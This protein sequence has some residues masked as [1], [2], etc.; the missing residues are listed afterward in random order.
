[1]ITSVET[2]MGKDRGGGGKLGE[3]VGMV[4]EGVREED[5]REG[6]EREREREKG[7]SRR[8]SSLDYTRDQASLGT[9]ERLEEDHSNDASNQFRLTAYP[10]MNQ[11]VKN[12]P[13]P[14][15]ISIDLHE[16]PDSPVFGQEHERTIPLT[17]SKSKS[18]PLLKSNSPVTFLSSSLP[19]P[20]LLAYHSEEASWKRATSANHLSNLGSLEE[21]YP[22]ERALG[23]FFEVLSGQSHHAQVQGGEKGQSNGDG[24]GNGNGNGTTSRSRSPIG[25]RESLGI[26][27]DVGIRTEEDESRSSLLEIPRGD[28][29]SSPTSSSEAAGAK[30]KGGLRP[31]LLASAT[32][33]LV[34]RL[35]I[36]PSEET[37]SRPPSLST[38]TSDSSYAEASPPVHQ[39]GPPTTSAR[40][41]I[42]SIEIF[43]DRSP[44]IYSAILSYL[45][46]GFLPSSFSL[47]SSPSHSNPQNNAFD[48]TH[49]SLY[50]LQPSAALSL[51]AKLRTLSTEAHWLGLE[52]LINLCEK[53]SYKVAEMVRVLEG[54][55]IGNGSTERRREEVVVKEK[56]KAAAG[57]I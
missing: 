10:Y 14:E 37:N 48:P 31:F 26:P 55:G 27:I 51:L 11:L 44:K 7:E 8:Y 23:P 1:M 33:P 2:L 5:R 30:P 56:A 35:E 34:P 20:A 28:D 50:T 40:G 18:K 6:L 13:G 47:P 41:G 43:L 15:S 17:L 12:Q 38:S 9:E 32:I 22:F 39:G 49:L 25:E 16:E 4:M 46:D 57:W 3:F 24:S 19:P 29:S 53:E 52:D 42:A 54:G 36:I 45:R 21:E